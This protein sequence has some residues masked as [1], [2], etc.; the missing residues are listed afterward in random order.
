MKVDLHVHTRYSAD[1]LTTLEDV[2]RW[3]LRRGMGAVA[4]T[5]HNTIQGARVLCSMSPIP[6]IVG[7]EI[8][9]CR[10]EISGLFMEKEIAPGQSPQETARQIHQQGGLVYI[11]HP[12]DRLRGSALGREA[13]L[14]ILDQ[15]DLIEILNARVAFSSDNERAEALARA[16][17]LLPG[18]GSDAHQGFEIGRAYVEMPAF[19]DA[20]SFMQSIAQGEIQG[21]L[22]SP[23]VHVGSGYAKVAKAVKALAGPDRWRPYGRW[24]SQ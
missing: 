16:Y 24:G 4:I 5:D 14:E 17:G 8:C 21:R 23:L 9:T 20:A 10:G 11:P 6:I 15:V 2:V 3:A 13:L 22:S 1:S 18:A 12:L 19:D 7:E